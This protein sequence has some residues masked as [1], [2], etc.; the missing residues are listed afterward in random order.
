MVRVAIVGTGD[1]AYGLANLF[2]NNNCEWSGYTLEV[3][4]PG[5]EQVGT[6]HDTGI[7]LQSFEN[8]LTQADIFIL[9]IPSRVLKSFLANHL[10][11]LKGKI[12]V[13]ATNST[14]LPMLLSATNVR[15]VKAFHD[16]P[17]V[18]LLEQQ[19]TDAQKVATKMITTHPTALVAVQ[20]FA[21]KCLG[22]NVKVVPF[23]HFRT[24]SQHEGSLGDEW[25]I[26]SFLMGTLL[27]F[28]AL[29]SVIR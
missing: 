8:S 1:L 14:D 5:S 28:T 9:A 11:S 12:L 15:W 2:R 24:A 21:E 25:L 10:V 20:Q 22:M 27:V 13:D 7:P 26:A 4:K 3:T 17:A 29:Y 16:V 18:R 23:Q 6:F 19:P